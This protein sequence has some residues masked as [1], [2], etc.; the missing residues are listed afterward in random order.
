M[1]YSFLLLFGI[2]FTA[3]GPSL[4]DANPQ[5]ALE[6]ESTKAS[7]FTDDS[8]FELRTYYCYPGRLEALK[9]R[10]RNHTL[11]LFE[12]HGM[13]NVAYWEPQDNTE[14]KLVYLL[15]YPN[16]ASRDSSWVAFSNDP[17]WKKVYQESHQEGPIVDSVINAFYHYSSFSP[18]LIAEDGQA[19][20]FSL[21]TYYTHPGKLDALR[22]RFA[23]H[24]LEIFEQNGIHNFVYLDL[25]STQTDNDNILTYLV[26]F[27][28]TMARAKSWASFRE[29]PA[30]KAAYSASIKDGKLVDSITDEVLLPTDF[31]PIK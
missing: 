26:T 8:F 25:D 7:A 19:R 14:N 15:A 17:E 31:S 28:D 18:K 13:T 10:F 3:C 16:R 6:Q 4:K 20:I 1:K 9:S 24:T 27:P 12:K 5:P 22:S 2:V 30:W 11:K 21:R 23:N 29:D